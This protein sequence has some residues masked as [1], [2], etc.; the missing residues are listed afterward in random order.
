VYQKA[1]GTDVT[2]PLGELLAACPKIEKTLSSETRLRM[3]PVTH[4]SPQDK[5]EDMAEAFASAY[6]NEFD[7]DYGLDDGYNR[8]LH[9]SDQSYYGRQYSPEPMGVHAAELESNLKRWIIS[10]GGMLAVKIG[11]R[12]GITALIDSGAKMNM[13]TP[14]LAE[15]LRNHYG[16]DDNGKQ[17][18]MKNVSGVVSNLK[19]QFNNIPVWIGG[20]W[21]NETFFIGDHWNS[22]L[23]V[24]L[25]QA[26]LPNNVCDLLWNENEECD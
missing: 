17:L 26:F 14:H 7:E 2:L 5:N 19:G 16:E 13:V 24:I 12:E 21:V 9:N 1:L 22:H 8:C 3:V 25:G 18:Q 10:P 20:A 6:V 4:T 15:E 11:H 23:D